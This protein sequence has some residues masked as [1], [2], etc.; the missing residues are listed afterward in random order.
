MN[1]RS[2]SYCS[3]KGRYKRGTSHYWRIGFYLQTFHRDEIQLDEV[4]IIEPRNL[5]CLRI[6]M[7]KQNRW[8]LFDTLQQLSYDND[9]NAPHGH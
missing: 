3:P 4:L 7:D 8:P 2:S 1:E 9:S 6:L 5:M